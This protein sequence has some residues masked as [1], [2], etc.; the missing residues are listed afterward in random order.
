MTDNERL[1]NILYEYILYEL[2]RLENELR[3]TQ[4]VYFS[5]KT[6]QNNYAIVDSW[7]KLEYFRKVAGEIRELIKYC[8]IE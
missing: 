6:P 1:V 4:N 7:V 8:S 2:S 3:N 5:N